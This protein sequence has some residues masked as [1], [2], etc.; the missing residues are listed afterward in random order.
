MALQIIIF[1]CASLKT[2]A[3]FL[4]FFIIWASFY[5]PL[6]G[7]T[8]SWS[9]CW[10]AIR[11][12]HRP[13]PS[14]R[15]VHEGVDGLDIGGQ[16]GRRFVLLR[17]THR[18]QRRSYLICVKQE[19]KRP[20]PVQRRLSR[21]QALLGS[22]IPGR[23]VCVPVSGIKVRSLVGYGRYWMYPTRPITLRGYL[24]VDRWSFT[25]DCT[26]NPTKSYRIRE[27]VQQM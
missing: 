9:R 7:S 8:R 17:H 24:E 25:T 6:L 22:V 16:H 21:T 26:Y 14:D 15:A 12:S 19:R 23:G 3:S 18:P 4:F 2:P 5:Y 10:A 27:L 11:L 20:T 1:H 13:E